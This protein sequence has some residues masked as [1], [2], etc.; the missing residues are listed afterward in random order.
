MNM[1]A[2]YNAR[3]TE[4]L[5]GAKTYTAAYA[6]SGLAGSLM[7][8]AL[9][10][11]N[12]VGASGAIMGVFGAF[13]MTLYDNKAIF[14]EA[15]ASVRRS[16]MTSVGLTLAL[17]LFVPLVDNWCAL[18]AALSS[19][20]IPSSQMA[21]ERRLRAKSLSGIATDKPIAVAE[22]TAPVRTQDAE[23]GG[24]CL[25]QPAYRLQGPSRGLDRWRRVHVPIRAES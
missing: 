15:S 11:H 19:T 9:S 4:R 5:L 18:R 7:S 10:P 12:S 20:A 14:G 1:N 16:L 25:R 17:G 13:W 23:S 8:Y 3:I 2:L 24:G 6:T 21:C 22:L